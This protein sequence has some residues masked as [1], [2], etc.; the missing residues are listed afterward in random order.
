MRILLTYWPTLDSVSAIV[1][2]P[3]RP[4]PKATYSIVIRGRQLG[5]KNIRIVVGMRKMKV[6]S[7]P[8]P[9]GKLR[10]TLLDAYLV[11]LE[12]AQV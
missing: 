3:D 9:P 11:T 8:V 2:R 6:T 4:I 7:Y 1:R 5:E 12:M 10:D